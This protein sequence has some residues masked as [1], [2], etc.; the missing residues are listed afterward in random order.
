MWFKNIKDVLAKGVKSEFWGEEVELD[1]VFKH[2]KKSRTK[3]NTSY[4][5]ILLNQFLRYLSIR[6]S[7]IEM[8][9]NISIVKHISK[10]SIGKNYRRHDEIGTP[11]CITVDFETLDNK[12]VTVRDRDTMEQKRLSSE[13]LRNYFNEYFN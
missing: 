9:K 3:K 5:K 7:K 2:Q 11:I 10:T 4:N 13:E 8:P 12:S 1:I 6:L